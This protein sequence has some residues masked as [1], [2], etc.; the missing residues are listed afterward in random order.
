MD[1]HGAARRIMKI[2]EC[3]FYQ[4]NK[5]NQ[6]AGRFLSERLAASNV[7]AVQ[8][9]VLNF[10]SEQDAVTS[11]QL[12]QRTK[13]D[14]ATLTGVLD[15]MEALGLVERRP[16]PDDR[17]AIL[18]CLTRRG[19]NLASD[20]HRTIEK[21]NRELLTGFGVQEERGLKAMLRRIHQG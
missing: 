4:L 3:I 13:M 14:S 18:I 12:G 10:L 21:A 11:K 6:A 19:K 8:G 15:R 2:E 16:N 17:R 5:A 1:P 20:V 9:V 7:T